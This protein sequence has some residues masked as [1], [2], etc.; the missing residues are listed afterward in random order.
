M[1]LCNNVAK[2]KK[3]IFNEF[4]CQRCF[5]K[6]SRFQQIKRHHQA[7]PSHKIGTIQPTKEEPVKT[8]KTDWNALSK[9]LL[10]KKRWFRYRKKR[11]KKQIKAK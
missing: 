10:K 3:K 8:E 6:F 9:K 4:Q 2:K 1:N 7:N 5:R 11:R